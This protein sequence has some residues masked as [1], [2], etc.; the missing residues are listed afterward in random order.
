MRRLPGRPCDGCTPHRQ[1]AVAVVLV[2]VD[3][4]PG[5]DRGPDDRAD[6]RPL[7]VLQHPDDNLPR[8]L[9]HAE[10]RRL[11]FLQGP[12]YP[13]TLE[14][15]PSAESLLL[16]DRLGMPLMPGRDV[17]LI[18]FDLPGEDDWRPVRD[19]A[20]PQSRG[21][22]SGVIEVR[23]QLAGDRLVGAVQAEELEAQ[24]PDPQGPEC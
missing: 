11:L 2:G 20:L 18:A 15:S 5:A 6:G 14:P 8:P 23:V 12:A 10:G 22:P 4:A 1:L 9:E 24:D 19:D 13:P 3:P 21:H 17:D 16:L 7:D